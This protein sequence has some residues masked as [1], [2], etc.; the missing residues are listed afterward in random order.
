MNFVLDLVVM[1][2]MNFNL[3]LKLFHQ[4]LYAVVIIPLP[5]SLHVACKKYQ[6]QLSHFQKFHQEF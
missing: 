5:Q 6:R 3:T 1:M 4:H 2:Y